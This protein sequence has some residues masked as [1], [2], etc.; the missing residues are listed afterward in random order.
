MR[1]REDATFI[2]LLNNL[3]VGQVNMEHIHILD[4]RRQLADSEDFVDAIC[5]FPTVKQ[6]EDYNSKMIDKSRENGSEV[7]Y[8]RAKNLSKEPKTFGKIPDLKYIPTDINE[9][10]GIPADLQIG[11]GFCI[12]L[13]RNINVQNGLVNGSMGSIIDIKWP[14]L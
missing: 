9:T 1:Q 4:E 5:I 10:A 2:N 14:N 8:I 12:M 11:I 13:R 7:F 6:V 3:R